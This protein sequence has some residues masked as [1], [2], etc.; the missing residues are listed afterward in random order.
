MKISWLSATTLATH[1]TTEVCKDHRRKKFSCVLALITCLRPWFAMFG[2]HSSNKHH[3]QQTQTNDLYASKPNQNDQDCWHTHKHHHTNTQTWT[4]VRHHT[5]HHT[6]TLTWTFVRH[7]S[8]GP[9]HCP[10]PGRQ[11]SP[12]AQCRLA[13]THT[14]NGCTATNI[15]SSSMSPCWNTHQ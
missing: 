3:G 12:P 8:P 10:R 6:N 1:Y 15:T 9:G 5:H 13:E 2:G 14:N 11:T 7:R 4:F